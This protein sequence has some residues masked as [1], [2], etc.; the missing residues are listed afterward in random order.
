MKNLSHFIFA[1]LLAIALAASA[2]AAVITFDENPLAPNSTFE[3]GAEVDFDSGGV[4][5]THEFTDFGGGCCWGN[6]TYSNDSDTT[7]AGFG[8]QFSA[9]TGDGAGAG[10]DNYG[11]SFSDGAYIDFG[12]QVQLS[13]AAFVTTTYTYLAVVNGDDGFPGFGI[14]PAD[15][16]VDA[17]DFLTLHIDGLDAAGGLLSSLSFDLARGTTILDSWTTIDLSGLGNIHSIAFSY[18]GSDVSGG[19]IDT[20]TYF[21]IDNI[22]YQAV[23]LPSAA[24]LFASA[25]IGLGLRR[26]A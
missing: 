12:Q 7:T 3:P 6:F 23:P 24:L 17:S 4:T 26:R 13:S 21:A 15:A 16:F 25:L 20:P 14:E 2:N 1:T 22:A 9:I 8:N 11:I 19:F 5:F 18:S 10:Q